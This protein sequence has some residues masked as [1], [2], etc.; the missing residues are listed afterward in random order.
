MKKKIFFPEK[1]QWCLGVPPEYVLQLQVFLTC[2][3]EPRGELFPSM[4][5]SIKMSQLMEP[6]VGWLTPNHKKK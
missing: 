2:L 3:K 5:R 6:K 4:S 1:Q